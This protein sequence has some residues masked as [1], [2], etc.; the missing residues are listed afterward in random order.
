[1]SVLKSVID[2]NNGNSGWTKQNLMDAFETALS[3]LGMNAGSSV[4]GVPQ[5]VMDPE[6]YTTQLG[7]SLSSLRQANG[8]DTGDINWGANK[9]HKYRVTDASGNNYRVQHY[10]EEYLY[11]TTF[12]DITN[13]RIRSD[14][15][16]FSTGD[17]VRYAKGQTDASYD[18]G[19]TITK[20][21][22]YYIIY[23][24]RDHFSLSTSLTN[25]NNGVKIDIDGY[26]TH[27]GTFECFTQEDQGTDYVNANINLYTG[28]YIE[29]QN[30]AG[31]ATN[32]T[33]CRDVDSFDT[34]QRIVYN[35][36]TYGFTP[37][38]HLKGARDVSTTNTISYRVNTTNI[39][40][41]PGTNLTWN[42]QT[43]PQSESEPLYPTSITN[44]SLTDIP[45]GDGT[46]KYIY[47]SETN[48]NAKGVINLIPGN[49]TQS[50]ASQI[51]NYPYW[52]YTVPVSGGRSEL[53]LRVQRY[54][55]NNGN[56]RNIT[57]HSIGTG[58]SDNDSFI[59][60]G[61]LVGGTATTGD[62]RFGVPTPETST[63][64]Y[65][66]TAGIKVT[67]LGGGSNLYQKADT[68]SFAVLNL[69]NNSTKKYSNTFYSLYLEGTASTQWTLKVQCGTG[70]EFLNHRGTSSTIETNNIEWGEF[71]G[72]M[73]LDRQDLSGLVSTNY[74]Y[75]LST[76]ST[77]TAYP[78]QIRTFRA[79][80]PQDPN[81]AVIQF[82]QTI[83][84]KIE[85]F[86][87]FN[88][89]LGDGYGNSVFDLDDVFLAGITEYKTDVTQSLRIETY[90]PGYASGYSQYYSPVG[91]PVDQ[92]TQARTAYYGYLR[93]N[94]YGQ[95]D[96]HRSYD[97]YRNNIKDGDQ[98][99]AVVYYRNS[100]YDKYHDMPVSSSA[101][102]YKPIKT[103]P[104]SQKMIPCPYY[105]PDD[106]V[107]LQ[108]ATT[109]GL[110]E[111]RPGDT[112][113]IS[114]SEIYEIIQASYQSQQT[115]LDGVSN[116]SSE[117]VLFL[118][119]T[120]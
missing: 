49:I 17:A 100:T 68:G 47:C 9:T 92:Y 66:G 23:V 81:F 91:E 118:A 4:T 54:G 111:F 13:D 90:M 41:A 59:I 50:Y 8:G 46:V 30:D 43:Y 75:I 96:P 106:F 16:G 86:A 27:T 116:N 114:G 103:I 51:N 38:S 14:R 19:T 24:D 98:N 37:K 3:N 119:R 44:P 22:I 95:S 55:Y 64:A 76:S 117:G 45:G 113:T 101:D 28:D 57:I 110:T 74:S 85:P 6:G 60:P 72:Y 39:S 31:N 105:M 33:L 15:H 97:D 29:F 5:I 62:I 2:V 77:P 42:T 10:V 25:A 109:P 88:F 94:Q 34:N 21:T 35:D 102:Y 87:A 7:G 56:L 20:N 65:D 108:V 40:C 112:V 52:K 104:I 83:N 99:E 18:L 32:F 73:G 82:T 11:N 12:V 26:T 67:T 79:Q 78:I 120:T 63:N 36:S 70:W 58:W 89:H 1:M 107:L 53:K 84:E 61:E 48:A 71:T 115:G 69:E 80:A 93:G